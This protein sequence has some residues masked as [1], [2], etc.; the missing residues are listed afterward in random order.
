MMNMPQTPLEVISTFMAALGKKDFD[1]ALRYLS[2][3]CEYTNIP[4]ST[5][6]GPVGVRTVLGGIPGPDTRE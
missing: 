4:V 2:D 1:T 5:V 6:H 3:D